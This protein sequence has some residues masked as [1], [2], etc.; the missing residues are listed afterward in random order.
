MAVD[1]LVDSTQLDADLTSVANAIRTKGG[2]SAQLAFPAGFVQAI[3]DIPSGSTQYPYYLGGYDEQQIV[4]LTA[5]DNHFRVDFNTSWSSSL[6]PGMRS[7]SDLNLAS[8]W[9]TI[10][11]GD[12]YEIAFYNVENPSNIQWNSNAKRANTSTSLSYGIGNGTHLDG[13]V[14]SGTQ[15]NT[16]DIGCWFCYL[17]TAA[18]DSYLAFD[19]SIKINGTRIL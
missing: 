4:R 19:M 5:R 16:E 2:T 11:A 6:T 12:T 15:V 13:A 9:F 8:K 1:K 14:V 3:G 18:A 7:F 10:N 17:A